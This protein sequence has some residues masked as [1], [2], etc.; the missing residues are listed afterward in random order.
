MY[1]CT[2]MWNLQR[3]HYSTL[4]CSLN[5][6]LLWVLFTISYLEVRMGENLTLEDG[7]DK[8]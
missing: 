2:N 1:V 6:M 4:K 7:C 8:H 5:D 3:N